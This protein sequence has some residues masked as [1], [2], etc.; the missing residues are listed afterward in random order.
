MSQHMN[1]LETTI[2]YSM[3][4][5]YELKFLD[6]W[7]NGPHPKI[8]SIFPVKNHQLLEQWEAYRLT[9]QKKEAE[10]YY[11]G[12]KLMCCIHLEQELC[13]SRGCGICRI[14]SDGFDENYISK[15][16]FQRFG[17]GFYLAPNSSKCHNY[18]LG[19]AGHRAMILFEV[20]PGKK[21]TVTKTD[22]RLTQP[23][24]HDSIYGKPGKSL[25]YP[26]LVIYNSHAALPKCIYVYKLNGDKMLPRTCGNT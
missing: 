12:T 2:P 16:S 25:H 22:E 26:E 4:K 14:A 6:A 1:I 7:N 10:E 11:H 20:L 17:P 5:V 19:T 21:F 15:T 18:T 9:L 23:A 24:D 13:D 3:L 8:T